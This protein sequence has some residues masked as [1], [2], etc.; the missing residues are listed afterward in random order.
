MDEVRQPTPERVGRHLRE[1]FTEA[2]PYRFVIVDRDSTDCEV[3]ASLSAT[4]LKAK[5]R[6]VQAPWQN[7]IAVPY[8][9]AP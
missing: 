2:G 9:A 6:S 5:W 7:R 3:V 4:E 1:T 8:P